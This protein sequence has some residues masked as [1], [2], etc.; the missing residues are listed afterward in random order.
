M[1][2]CAERINPPM[3]QIFSSKYG[4]AKIKTFNLQY[5][6]QELFIGVG[7]FETC[8]MLFLAQNISLGTYTYIISLI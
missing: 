4:E 8:R 7:L 2:R 5:Y 6:K 3:Y 1:S